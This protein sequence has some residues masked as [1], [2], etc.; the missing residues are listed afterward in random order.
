[1]RRIFMIFGILLFCSHAFAKE[2]I[3]KDPYEQGFWDGSE[4]ALVVQYE[5]DIYDDYKMLK[6]LENQKG[7]GIKEVRDYFI[8]TLNTT[9]CTL[10]HII[11]DTD[12]KK[13][14]SPS[15]FTFIKEQDEI[16][17]RN[18][19]KNI[20]KKKWAKMEESME[21]PEVFWKR[22]K[23]EREQNNWKMEIKN[24]ELQKV[25]EKYVQLALE[26]YIQYGDTFKTEGS[27]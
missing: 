15:F 23:K 17:T 3:K 19:E 18:I 27:R 21:S 16:T 5:L 20:G 2:P 25:F 10:G 7:E 6:K 24:E 9:L 14:F 4:Y 8:R 1:M 26:R 11:E 22:L 12:N 13:I